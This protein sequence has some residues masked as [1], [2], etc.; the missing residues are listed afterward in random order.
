MEKV[1]NMIKQKLSPERLEELAF[2]YLQRYGNSRSLLYS[3]QGAFLRLVRAIIN[4]GQ[5]RVNPISISWFK[6]KCGDGSCVGAAHRDGYFTVNDVTELAQFLSALSQAVN[7]E[8]QSY[9]AS[10]TSDAEQEA[11]VFHQEVCD[12]ANPPA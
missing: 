4:T 9:F 12:P 5:V 8:F 10:F 6:L 3:K 2:N 11:E 1:H 7:D